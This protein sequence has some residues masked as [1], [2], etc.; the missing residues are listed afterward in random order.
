MFDLPMTRDLVEEAKLIGSRSRVRIQH[1]GF[2]VYHNLIM[3]CRVIS[4][5]KSMLRLTMPILPACLPFSGI[6]GNTKARDM[7]GH[8]SIL[9]LVV[10]RTMHGLLPIQVEE[11]DML[12]GCADTLQILQLQQLSKR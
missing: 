12:Q 3:L 2:F 8:R 10:V 9:V 4:I 7:D 11:V 6:R 5:F 1:T